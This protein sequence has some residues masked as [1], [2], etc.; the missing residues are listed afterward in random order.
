MATT[1]SNITIFPSTKTQTINKLI[2]ENS[3]TRL[4][5]RLVDVDSYI[6]TPT[7]EEGNSDI[8]VDVNNLSDSIKTLE[9][10][11]HGYYFCIED[12]ND[13]LSLSEWSDKITQ[14][15]TVDHSLYAR[16]FIDKTNKDY[17]EI[18]GTYTQNPRTVVL[19]DVFVS[20]ETCIPDF[21]GYSKTIGVV[22][23]DENDTIISAPG[24]VRL[25]DREILD[26]DD[27]GQVSGCIYC[28]DGDFI[29]E[30]TGADVKKIRLVELEFYNGIQI[31]V[32]PST[33]TGA[34]Y[35]PNGDEFDPTNFEY[36]DLCLLQWKKP[37]DAVLVS[38]EQQFNTYIPLESLHK[39]TS[40]SIDI[41]DGGEIKVS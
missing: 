34:I 29:P 13:L 12:I 16:I 15:P 1:L 6:I 22:L 10:C 3:V 18:M 30:K 38:G 33:E 21:K 27:T 8:L 28:D 19:T 25:G 31:Y 9:F 41:I 23:L 14:D 2:T 37:I 40:K 17:P 20:G 7:T 36:Y 24:K 5:N 26:P 32:D 39:F 35:M 4:I 11:I